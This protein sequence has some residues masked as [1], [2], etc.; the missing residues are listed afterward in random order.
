MSYLF[1][2]VLGNGR[3]RVE[4]TR[5]GFLVYVAVRGLQAADM[6]QAK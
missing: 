3:P 2:L 1:R 6:L 4:P 5:R